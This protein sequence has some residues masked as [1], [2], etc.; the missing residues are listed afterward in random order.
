MQDFIAHKLEHFSDV[1]NAFDYKIGIYLPQSALDYDISFLER[2][3][4]GGMPI[5]LDDTID[6]SPVKA[7]NVFTVGD[8]EWR[9]KV[10]VLAPVYFSGYAG[11]GN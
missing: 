2:F 8:I 4:N 10:D 1:L 6:T 7:T 11:R 9:E 5:I 3:A